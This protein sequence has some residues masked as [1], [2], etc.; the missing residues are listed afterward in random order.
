MIC[1]PAARHF[2]VLKAE[3]HECLLLQKDFCLYGSA[4][5]KFE[6]IYFEDDFKKRRTLE[7]N[8]I[9]KD[10]P[11]QRYN[12]TNHSKFEINKSQL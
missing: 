7:K 10:L 8:L 4:F 6:I 5:L 2:T 11:N 3:Y 12:I 9:N 1:A